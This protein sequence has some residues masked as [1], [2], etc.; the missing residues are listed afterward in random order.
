[1]KK[2]AN[3]KKSVTTV[4]EEST[5]C[6]MTEEV[7]KILIETLDAKIRELVEA[8]DALMSGTT[9]MPATGT[10]FTNLPTMQPMLMQSVAPSKKGHVSPEAKER[11]S[12]RMKLV[13]AVRNATQRGNRAE[14]KAAKERLEEWDRANPKK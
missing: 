4:K 1:V 11:L 9:I 3:V 8:R 2:P 14:I 6:A 10:T 12:Q 5:I 7:R 13:W